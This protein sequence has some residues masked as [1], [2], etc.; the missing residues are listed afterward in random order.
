ML[1]L[2]MIPSS[3]LGH[4]LKWASRFMLV[5]GRVHGVQ[6]SRLVDLKVFLSIIEDSQM[7]GPH[8]MEKDPPHPVNCDF[9]NCSRTSFSS[10]LTS[11]YTAL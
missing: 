5:V 11:K 1:Y 3:P 4:C 7:L 9:K 2:L 6:L 10:Q 8:S